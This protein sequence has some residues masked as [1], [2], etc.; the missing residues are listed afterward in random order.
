MWHSLSRDVIRV[1]H[2]PVWS[3]VPGCPTFLATN[4]IR[5]IVAHRYIILF[6]CIGFKALIA[7]VMKNS[8]FWVIMPCNPKSRWLAELGSQP[9]FMLISLVACSSILK[10]EATCSSETSIDFQ[11]TT[12]RYIPGGRTLHLPTV[13]RLKL[14][15]RERERERRDRERRRLVE[16]LCFYVEKPKLCRKFPERWEEDCLGSCSRGGS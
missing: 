16:S 15:E 7:V 10:M 11:Q 2:L 1:Q 13:N 14:E 8:G 9:A 12:R 5:V 3:P 6:I 4:I